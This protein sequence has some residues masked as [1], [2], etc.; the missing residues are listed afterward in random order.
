MK[1]NPYH[2]VNPQLYSKQLNKAEKNVSTQKQDKVE[3]SS[4]AKEM[5]HIPSYIIEREKKIAAL[6]QQV[7]SGQY[8]IDP[9]AIA[10]GIAKFFGKN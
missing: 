5:Q 3:I 10:K 1:I 2:H 7:Q 8:E 4:E 6:K 9:K